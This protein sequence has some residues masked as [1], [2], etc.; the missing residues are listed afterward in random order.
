[1]FYRFAAPNRENQFHAVL[2]IHL[3]NRDS[4]HLFYCVARLQITQTPHSATRRPFAC[5]AARLASP[6]LATIF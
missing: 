3:K 4:P 5:Q 6:E 2:T 1:M